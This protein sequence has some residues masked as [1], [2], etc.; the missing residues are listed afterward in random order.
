VVDIFKNTDING[1]TFVKNI[2]GITKFNVN[3]LNS[4]YFYDYDQIS[5]LKN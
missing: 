2:G 3:S 5:P 4:T 1:L